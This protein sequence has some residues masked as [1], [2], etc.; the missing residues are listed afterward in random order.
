[1][2]AATE[3]KLTR[4]SKLTTELRQAILR[5]KLVP[6]QKISLDQ[7]REEH[8][9]S[10]SPLR[11]AISRLMSSGLVE[12]EDQRGTRIA[13]VSV[14]NLS[15]IIELR[16]SL[17][18]RAL[19]ASVLAADIDWES[20]VLGALHKLRRVE[21]T[22][23]G[24]QLPAGYEPAMRDFHAA[25]TVH[26]GMPIL[27]DFCASLTDLYMRYLYL[28]GAGIAFDPALAEDRKAI[29]DAAVRRDAPLAETLM[30]RHIT[31]F[32]NLLLQQATAALSAAPTK[33]TP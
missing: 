29:V 18:S 2:T 16:A 32:G 5:G 6:G 31:A 25:L 12:M 27:L 9:V 3:I 21:P 19:R 15:E 8:G 1:M 26:S 30:S 14:A 20:R 10:L 4:A 28:F 23:G 22:P 13:P 17:E 33:A 11:E 7:L 24:T